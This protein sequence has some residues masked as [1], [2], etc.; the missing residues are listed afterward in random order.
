MKVSCDYLYNRIVGRKEAFSKD[1]DASL[2]APIAAD[3]DTV[4]TAIAQCA[5]VWR[6]RSL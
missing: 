1:E 5:R 6:R 2:I 3:Y 4:V